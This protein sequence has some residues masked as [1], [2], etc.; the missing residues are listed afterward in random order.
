[1]P[2]QGRRRIKPSVTKMLER[3]AKIKW[4]IGKLKQD[5]SKI[6]REI[7]AIFQNSKKIQKKSDF[8]WTEDA[9]AAFRQ[10]KEHTAKL[11]MLIAPEEQEKLIV[12]LAASKEAVSA[13]L[14]T[15]R[16]ARQMQIYFVSRGPEARQMPIDL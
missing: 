2:R 8:L 1:M 7:I 9:E 4:K 14:M 16:E 6:S 15:K 12:Y 5:L 13:V 11:P 3:R 10:M